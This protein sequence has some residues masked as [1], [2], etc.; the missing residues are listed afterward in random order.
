MSVCRSCG[1]EIK[2]ALTVN[3]KRMPLDAEPIKPAP[4]TFILGDGT[5]GYQYA[6]AAVPVYQSHFASCPQAASHRKSN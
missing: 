2:W 1:A 4:G 5:D 6:T 3:G